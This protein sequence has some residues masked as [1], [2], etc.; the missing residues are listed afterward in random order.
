MCTMLDAHPH[1]AMGYELYE[2]LLEP[3]VRETAVSRINVIK[4]LARLTRRPSRK[5]EVL[6]GRALRGGVSNRA[7]DRLVWQQID[8]GEGFASFAR[9][10]RFIEK[11]VD[12]KRQ[13]EG[14]QHWGAKALKPDRLLKVFPP[15]ECYFLFMQRDGR[16]VAASQ[17]HV[18]DFKKEIEQIAQSWSKQTES[19]HHFC[20][21]NDTNARVIR[22]ESLAEEP[23][24]ISKEI[25]DFLGVDWSDRML[26]SHE[27]DLSI[28]RNPASHLSTEQIKQAINTKSVGRYKS[29]LTP[30]ELSLFSR[31]AGEALNKFGY[32]T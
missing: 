16:D 19:F 7:F 9:R 22:Y 6:S 14:K 11:L 23:E 12:V 32:L 28:H 25:C 26:H 8:K 5:F 10:M 24:R 27:L 20:K 2:H 18:G 13:K 17:K 21:R 15:E 30:D 31:D 1:I 3:L 4:R 29:D